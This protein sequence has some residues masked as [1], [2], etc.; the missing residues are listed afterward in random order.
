MLTAL[1]L[2]LDGTLLDTPE[3]I[4]RVLAAAL[5]DAGHPV[6]V[7]AARA[8]VGLPLPASVA[9]LAGLPPGSPAVAGLVADY[10]ARV[11]GEAES[12][13]RALVRPGVGELFLA[14][15]EAGVPAAV[16]TSRVRA[17]AVPLLRAAGLL[18]RVAAVV[19]DDDVPRPKP[20]P[21]MARAALALLDREASGAL[22]VGDGWADMAMAVAAGCRAVGVAGGVGT[23]E[24]LLAAG[25]SQVLDGPGAV[26]GLLGPA[27]GVD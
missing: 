18:D 26:T 9:A 14:A 10:R 8:T 27:P 22:V 21:A 5:T 23:R 25:A 7:A 19:C 13:A 15:A 16:V 1:L 4:A 24:E 6:G 20:D 2:D 11:A 12:R 17:T 3:V